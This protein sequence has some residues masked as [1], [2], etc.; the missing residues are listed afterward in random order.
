MVFWFDNGLGSGT[1]RRHVI[2]H[3]HRIATTSLRDR[4]NISNRISNRN[5]ISSRNHNGTPPARF[6]I[7]VAIALADR[8]RRVIVRRRIPKAELCEF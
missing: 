7:A 6:A 3:R 5:R 2:A 8:F 1:D 4:R